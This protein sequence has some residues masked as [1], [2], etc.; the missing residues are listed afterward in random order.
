[1]IR[2]KHYLEP[3]NIISFVSCD[4]RNCFLY[5]AVIYKN[6]FVSSE[7]ER[8]SV[9]VLPKLPGPIL[10]HSASHDVPVFLAFAGTYCNYR[11]MAR[12]S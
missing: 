7:C 12:L 2:D 8:K 10:D 3:V 9:K 4:C 5:V 11:G 6:I 1:M